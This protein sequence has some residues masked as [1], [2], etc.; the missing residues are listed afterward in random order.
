MLDIE[1]YPDKVK[2]PPSYIYPFDNPYLIQ[3]KFDMSKYPKLASI[4]RLRAAGL[5]TLPGFVVD[6]LTQ[7]TLDYLRIWNAGLN[8]ERLSLRFDSPS[9]EDHKRLMGSNPTLEELSQMD[10]FFKPPVIGIIM[11]ENDR[12]NQDHSVLTRFSESHL[13]CEIVGP[14]FD[15]A[16]I[17]RGNVSPHETFEI[18]R[19]SDEDLNLEFCLSDIK[20]HE[21]TKDAYYKQSRRLR[22]GVIF[23]ILEKGLGKAVISKDLSPSQT[24]R[25]EN[26]LD[27]R[28]VTIPDTYTPLGLNRLYQL[29]K[30][31]G[32]LSAFRQYY[33]E[34]FQLDVE[35]KV[36]SASFLKKYGLVFWDL[37]GANKYTKR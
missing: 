35:E 4:I 9:P 30:H 24:S 6:D 2:I 16:D 23:S 21:V 15:A 5:P 3:S 27:D 31:I 32:Q 19:R 34:H 8:A 18:L 12:F 29:Y 20:K 25:V 36:L 13:L 26:F 11:A 1:P 14:G 10:S 28:G 37:Y 22:Y 33:K 17:T 7:E